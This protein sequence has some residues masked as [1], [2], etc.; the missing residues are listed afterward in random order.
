MGG[1]ICVCTDTG[2]LQPDQYYGSGS[3]TDFK[4]AYEVN[5]A[6]RNENKLKWYKTFGKYTLFVLSRHKQWF[7]LYNPKL[8]VPNC[9]AYIL[10]NYV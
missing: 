7:D 3:V 2:D 6:F 5:R 4:Y 1:T 8:S 10:Y 9:V